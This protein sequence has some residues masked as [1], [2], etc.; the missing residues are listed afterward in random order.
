VERLRTRV[1]ELGSRDTESVRALLREELLTLVGPTP[2][3]RCAR[4]GR[5]GGQPS[6]SSSA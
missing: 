5:T 4:P 6:S 1:K 2:T 3:G